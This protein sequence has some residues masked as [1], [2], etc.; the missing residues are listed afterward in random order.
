MNIMRRACF[1]KNHS[2]PFARLDWKSMCV[3]NFD[4]RDKHL[5]NWAKRRALFS[6][7]LTF[8]LAI[9]NRNLFM[10]NFAPLWRH[11]HSFQQIVSLDLPTKFSPACAPLCMREKSVHVALVCKERGRINRCGERENVQIYI[12]GTYH[13]I[14]LS[15]RLPPHKRMSG[16]LPPPLRSHADWQHTSRKKIIHLFCSSHL[17]SLSLPQKKIAAAHTSPN[18][19]SQ[20]KNRRQTKEPPTTTSS[21]WRSRRF[22]FSSSLS[23]PSTLLKRAIKRAVSFVFR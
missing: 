16:W 1:Q 8:L 14:R 15:L 7:N 23:L 6:R 5:W 3:L 9:G 4:F 17:C 11:F 10:R 21:K 22:A 19:G 18:C 20:K 12:R 13:A 2:S